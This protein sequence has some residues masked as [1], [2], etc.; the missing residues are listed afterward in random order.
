M[1]ENIVEMRV[2]GT[3]IAGAGSRRC[4]SP[5]QRLAVSGA[6]AAML[7]VALIAGVAMHHR[8]ASSPSAPVISRAVTSQQMRLLENNTT[9]LPNAVT[10][11]VRPVVIPSAQ[12]RFLE[13]NTM[14]PDVASSVISME[15]RKF[16]AVNTMLPVGTA[17]AYM[18]EVT[19][20]S[21]QPR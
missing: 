17:N 14:L 19:P 20:R 2:E 1:A 7:A 21:D 6:A 8:G 13:G 3:S 9:N 5:M 11:D 18:E 15:Q 16:L 10:S 4:G 12:Q